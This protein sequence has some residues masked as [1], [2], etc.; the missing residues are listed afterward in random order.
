MIDDYI[1]LA[2]G[3]KNLHTALM[4]VKTYS[5]DQSDEGIYNALSL[6]DVE[7]NTNFADEF[8]RMVRR[9]EKQYLSS[10]NTQ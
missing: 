5:E 2:E 3:N 10:N 7:N 6:I 9:V 4:Q 8:V 1:T